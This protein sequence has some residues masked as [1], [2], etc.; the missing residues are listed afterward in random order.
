MQAEADGERAAAL[1]AVAA[2]VVQR[3]SWFQATQFA[4]SAAGLAAAGHDDPAF[5]RDF[6]AAAE[7]KLA[8]F[9][10]GQLS[11]ILEVLAR[12]G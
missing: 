9:T 4:E 3:A 12:M 11:S 10:F 1:A 5:W 8:S 6:T 7:R 2:L